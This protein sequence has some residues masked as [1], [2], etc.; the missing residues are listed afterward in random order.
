MNIYSNRRV[1]IEGE[2]PLISST[3]TFPF[4]VKLGRI[5]R[6]K[7]SSINNLVFRKPRILKTQCLTS[8]IVYEGVIRSVRLDERGV[9]VRGSPCS[10]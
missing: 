4:N 9:G 10:I 5:Y 3:Q 1:S 6:I 2:V 8:F 7:G